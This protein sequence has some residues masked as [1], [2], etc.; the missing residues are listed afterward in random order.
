M[1]GKR[2][3]I[4]ALFAVVPCA[5]PKPENDILFQ[6]AMPSGNCAVVYILQPGTYKVQT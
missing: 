1:S 4:K 6:I 2:K 3:L 5:A